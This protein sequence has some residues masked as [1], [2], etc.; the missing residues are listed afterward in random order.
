[1][2][3]GVGL[4]MVLGYIVVFTLCFTVTDPAAL[5]ESPTG[6]PMIQLFYDVTKS[7]AG[8]SIMSAIV[9]I[10]LVSAVISEIATASR[11][12][13]SFARDK[14]LPFSA[15]L[16]KVST[17]QPIAISGHP[18]PLHF[19][20][21]TVYLQV[22][23]GW[24][25]PLNAVSVN[26]AFGVVIALLNLGSA[27]ALNAIASL[28][29]SALLS[30]YFLSIGCFITRR[31]RSEPLP[32]S[33]FSLG[34]WGMPCNC[35]AMAF[36]FSFFIF[37]FNPTDSKPTAETMNWNIAMFGG[38]S[39]FATVYYLVVGRKQYRPPVDILNRDRQ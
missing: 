16:S 9:I 29:M 20:P 1:M 17:H 8:T 21:L 4:N 14:G 25:I 23:P 12:I 10:T 34:K 36:L 38:I 19:F 22:S 39:I 7:K 5:L 35:I 37:C 24:N 30:S 26:M 28:T 13:W 33:R 15:Q 32:P 27:A 6:Y 11:Q 3:W 18:A 2:L 31:L